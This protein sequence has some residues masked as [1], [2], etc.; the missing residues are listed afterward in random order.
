MLHEQITFPQSK[1]LLFLLGKSQRYWKI[2]HYIYFVKIEFETAILR[3]LYM[4]FCQFD[5]SVSCHVAFIIFQNCQRELLYNE[6]IGENYQLNLN[7]LKIWTN[8]EKKIEKKTKKYRKMIKNKMKRSND[9]TTIEEILDIYDKYVDTYL[10]P[11]P[12][13]VV[14]S[15]DPGFMVAV[16]P[17]P[18]KACAYYKCKKIKCVK[19][20]VK[21]KIC[22]GCKMIYYCS[23]KCQKRDWNSKHRTICS[24]LAV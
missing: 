8:F 5:I 9:S 12:L 16:L 23:R 15:D 18:I 7:Y 11:V 13:I 4:S 17:E 1:S 21:M 2:Q 3:A 10:V 24:N 19:N 20:D 22:K 14:P 6:D